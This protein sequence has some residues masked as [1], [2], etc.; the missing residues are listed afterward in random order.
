VIGRAGRDFHPCDHSLSDWGGVSTSLLDELSPNALVTRL[1][2]FL[3]KHGLKPVQVAR[4]SGVSRQHLRRVRQG[5]MEPS[6]WKIAQIVSALRRLTLME[7]QPSDVFELTVEE[8]GTWALAEVREEAARRTETYRQEVRAGA[9]FVKDTLA[10]RPDEWRHR[11]IQRGVTEVVVRQL[12]LSAH[13]ILDAKPAR[14]IQ[15]LA[16]A[17]GLVDELPPSTSE[18]LIHAMRGRAFL[19]RAFAN[20]VLGN[21]HEAAVSLDS[22]DAEYRQHPQCTHEL[23]QAWY[24]RAALRFKLGD[25][26]ATMTYVHQARSIFVLTGDRRRTAR[27]RMIEACVLVDRNL[28]PRAREAFREAAMIFRAFEDQEALAC[29]LLNWG[30][31]E[32]R[33][34]HQVRAR[35]LFQNALALFVDLQMPGEIVR[36]RWNLAHLVTFYEDI[37]RG[38]PLLRAVRDEFTKLGMIG[39]AAFVGL[40][41]VR[42]L[43]ANEEPGEAAAWCRRIIP[44][45]ETSGATKNVREALAYLRAAAERREATADLAA[46]V[47]A[48]I[49]RAP[50]HPDSVFRTVP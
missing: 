33:L 1:E 17:E 11:F 39:D 35:K 18:Y 50:H 31:T 10:A 49:E 15:L 12:L 26:D 2:F 7:V 27:A 19:D 38:L 13:R 14:A 22:A 44:E 6:R 9:S 47:R 45:F 37:G 8:N 36:T 29:A 43:Y 34:R 25:L 46:E 23:G 20:R 3:V 16:V 4:E 30:S 32:M 21:F 28:L 41:L 24:E 48:F 40:D 42:A 5:A